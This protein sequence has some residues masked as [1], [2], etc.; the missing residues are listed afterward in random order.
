MHTIPHHF[1]SQQY[2]GRKFRAFVRAFSRA[3]SCAC[4]VYVPRPFSVP[5]FVACVPYSHA[6]S[7]CSCVVCCL[8]TFSLFVPLCHRGDFP[9]SLPRRLPKRLPSVLPRE[10]PKQPSRGLPIVTSQGAYQVA[11]LAAPLPHPHPALSHIAFRRCRTVSREVGY[12]CLLMFDKGGRA[13]P[14]AWHV[15]WH[16]RQL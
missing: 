1:W 6:V 2:C 4:S 3:F 7:Y 8:Y 13:G 5:S 14:D 11:S 12:I 16:V 15:E 10:L 9:G